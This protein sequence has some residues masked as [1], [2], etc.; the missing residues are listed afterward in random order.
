MH[1]RKLGKGLH[2]KIKLFFKK[3]THIQEK[4]R[5]RERVRGLQNQT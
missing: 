3:Q 2:C 1:T 4:E 5:E